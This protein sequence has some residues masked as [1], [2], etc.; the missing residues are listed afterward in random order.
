MLE[1]SAIELS[2]TLALFWLIV[3]S[4]YLRPI[5]ALIRARQGK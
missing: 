4:L 5:F 3:L 2:A 1:F